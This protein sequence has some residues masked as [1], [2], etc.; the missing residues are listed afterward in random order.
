MNHL[1]KEYIEEYQNFPKAGINFLDLNPIYKNPSL[2]KKL[3]KDCLDCLETFMNSDYNYIATVESRGFIIGSILANEL[4]KGIILL[5]SKKKRLPGKVY[6]ATYDLEYGK[7]SVE[8]QAGSGKILIF[9]D[10][11]A[12]G[13]TTTGSIVCLNKAGYEPVGALYLVEL[14]FL[15]PQIILPYGSIIQYEK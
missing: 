15:N 1:Y 9:D 10:V 13:G 4:D 6:S 2:R 8:V 5:R 11:L 7:S 3:V 12:T 14:K